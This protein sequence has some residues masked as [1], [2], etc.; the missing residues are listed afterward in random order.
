VSQIYLPLELDQVEALRQL[1][2]EHGRHLD[3]ERALLIYEPAIIG[4]ANVHFVDRKR[5]ISEQVEKV[6]LAPVPL[7]IGGV[8]WDLAEP[9]P[10][11]INE[12]IV[13]RPAPSSD[14]GPY[15]APTPESANDA[16]KL[17][18]IERSL[19]D[20]LYHDSR[21][22]I[23]VHPELDVFHRPDEPERA[24]KA[25]L[26]QAAR[27]RRDDEVDKLEE[28]C[29][30]RI[31]R[32]EA[33]LRKEERDLIAD[34]ADYDARRREA[35]ITLGETI[36]SF[37]RGRRRTRAISTVA[38]KRRMAE[39]AKL[40]VEETR[41]EIEGLEEEIDA[42][43]AELKSSA[44]DI[45]RK[46]TDLL[47]DLAVE[48]IH[49]RRTDIDVRLVALAWLPSWLVTYD[50]GVRSREATIAAFPVREGRVR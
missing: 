3:V 17:K 46:W 16:R 11:K 34:E 13:S 21:L 32:L 33:R 10:L 40:D 14:F 48:E 15:F 29:E 47:D 43:E 22:S 7:E 4:G 25:R 19:A 28:K 39:Q 20:W 1:S 45:T 37:F 18:T 31:D 26:R 36:F 9:L 23:T 8:D 44:K 27:E 24:F 38:S 50:D 2:R 6:L 5:R 12:V 35:H 30:A 41:L 49:P 42:L